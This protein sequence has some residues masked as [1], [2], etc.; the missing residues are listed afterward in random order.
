MSKERYNQELADHLRT[1]IEAILSTVPAQRDNL[2]RMG[3]RFKTKIQAEYSIDTVTLHSRG[4]VFP[5]YA[6]RVEYRTNT[7]LENLA[8]IN[9]LQ[10]FGMELPSKAK[11]FYLR[12]L[13]HPWPLKVAVRT[14]PWS[15]QFLRLALFQGWGDIRPTETDFRLAQKRIEAIKQGPTLAPEPF[16]SS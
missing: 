2:G 1:D 16:L 6:K 14:Y 3:R 13:D 12:G 4:D 15:Q 11:W 7:G 5:Q 8:F 9:T 10:L